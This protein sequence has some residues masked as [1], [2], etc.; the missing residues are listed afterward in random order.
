MYIPLIIGGLTLGVGLYFLFLPKAPKAKPGSI[1]I[2]GDSLWSRGS[3]IDYLRSLG[4]PWSVDNRSIVGQ[5][6]TREL[7]LARQLI[8]RRYTNVII[9]GGANDLGYSSASAVINRLKQMI[10]LAEQYGSTVT[11][12]TLPAMRGYVSWNPEIEAKAI[13]INQTIKSFPSVN[14]IDYRSILGNPLSSNFDSGDHLHINR[15][16]QQALIPR[17]REIGFLP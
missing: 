17:I 16:G 9:A 8:P 6:T 11:I 3:H 15:N 12:N 13:E 5:P 10:Q 4:A 14:I 1:L 2:L 7:T